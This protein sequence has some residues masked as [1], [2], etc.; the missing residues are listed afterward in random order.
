M[1]NQ[2]V[3]DR[4]PRSV[5]TQINRMQGRWPD[6]RRLSNVD[7]GYISWVG[8]LRGFQQPYQMRIF[9]TLE[10]PYVQLIDPPLKPRDGARYE[11]IPHLIFYDEKPE[12]SALCL[13]D[14]NGREWEPNMLIADTTVPW[15]ADWLKHYEFWHY[16]G[17]WRGKS[18]GPESVPDS[19]T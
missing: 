9:W 17:I 3:T 19:G 16:D 4:R 13:F 18:I 14:P 10:K 8:P 12:L 7:I 15:A 5:W 2:S 11:E 6:F 1:A